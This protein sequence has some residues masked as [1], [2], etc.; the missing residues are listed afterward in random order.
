MATREEIQQHI[1]ALNAGWQRFDKME[2]RE[3]ELLKR[4]RKPNAKHFAAKNAA[5]RTYS[6]ALNWLYEQGVPDTLLVH[7]RETLT[8]TIPDATLTAVASQ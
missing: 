6:A 3:E 7:E 5:N 4:G 1:D 8:W 2:K